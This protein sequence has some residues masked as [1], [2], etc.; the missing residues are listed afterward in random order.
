VNKD[1]YIYIIALLKLDA[2][3]FDSLVCTVKSNNDGSSAALRRA[4]VVI[5]V[6]AA[7]GGQLNFW[8]EE[9]KSAIIKSCTACVLNKIQNRI[10]S[11]P[12]RLQYLH[13]LLWVGLGPF[14]IELVLVK[15]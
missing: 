3:R 15:Q 5:Q 6:P 7:S 2:Q 4:A 10:D 11:I 8:K 14:D 9:M 1:V 12:G 13:A